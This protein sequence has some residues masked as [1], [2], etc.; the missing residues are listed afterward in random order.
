MSLEEE[1]F[2]KEKEIV[3]A[4]MRGDFLAVAALLADGFLEIGGSGRVYSKTEV[5]D[6]LQ[7]ARI[8]DCAFTEFKGLHISTDCVI[9]TY[10]TNMKRRQQGQEFIQRAHRS[11]TWIRR[12]GTWRIIFHQATP[13]PDSK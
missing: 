3:A 9:I 2:R 11:S 5:L 1:L 7:E 8:L 10:M 6:A 12:D 4:A 13:L